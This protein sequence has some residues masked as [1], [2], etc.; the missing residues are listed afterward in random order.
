MRDGDF[1]L[2]FVRVGPEQQVA[3]LKFVEFKRLAAG[4]QNAVETA[5]LSNPRV[6]VV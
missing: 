3:G 6:L 4:A 2:D 5:L 1:A